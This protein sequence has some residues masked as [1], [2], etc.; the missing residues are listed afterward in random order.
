MDDLGRTF[1]RHLLTWGYSHVAVGAM[2]LPSVHIFILQILEISDCDA[3]CPPGTCYLFSVGALSLRLEL[4]F[5]S[6]S[7][8]T[9]SW[10][11]LSQ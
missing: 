2:D 8:Q 9:A 1:L 4:R 5:R 10:I 6:T 3:S 11:L 7:F